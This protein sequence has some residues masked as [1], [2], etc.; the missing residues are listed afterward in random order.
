MML[1]ALKEDFSILQAKEEVLTLPNRKTIGQD[2]VLRQC[3]SAKAL[4]LSKRMD[5][6]I[7]VFFAGHMDTVY[8]KDS[9]FQK[10]ESEK[11]L[12]K[13]P[14]VADMK[15]GL[16]ILLYGLNDFEKT[17][18]AKNIGWEILINPDEEIGSPASSS[19]FTESA[20]RHHLGIIFEPAFSDGAFVC[21]RKGSANYAIIA[22]GVESHSGR[23]FHQGKSAVFALCQLISAIEKLNK[24][25]PTTT[26]NVGYVH[27]GGP[28]N[29]VPSFALCKINV[30]AAA[31][32]SM[33]KAKDA[34]KHIVAKCEKREGIRLEMH[35]ETARPPKELDPK[36]RLLFDSFRECSLEL[37]IPFHTRGSG[38]VC[39]GNLLAAAGLPT[40]DTAGAVGG[41]I[42]TLNEYILVDSL[43]ERA[44]LLTLFL[45][46]LSR[47][48]LPFSKEL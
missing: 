15:G 37:S 42:H 1:D 5:A 28:V 25:D 39:D 45:K 36:T 11:G 26:F 33:E 35:E 18:D 7:K 13:G 44:S 8:P 47:G 16:A 21:E 23:D 46:K 12:L 41:H 34:L 30:R 27:G 22:R 17:A 2:G 14:G 10:A 20:K 9:P 19:L 38:G 48:E 6:K 32:E 4:R 31:K 3:P 29:I 24:P 40:L 43:K